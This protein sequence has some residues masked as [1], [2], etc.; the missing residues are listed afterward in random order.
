MP[1]VSV[2]ETQQNATIETN[3]LAAQPGGVEIML[4]VQPEFNSYLVNIVA[5]AVDRIKFV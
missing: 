3:G 4:L 2:R 5:R 1:G